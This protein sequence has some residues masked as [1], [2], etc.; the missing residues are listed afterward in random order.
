MPSYFPENN[1]PKSG[2]SA[3]RVLH[4][5]LGVLGGDEGLNTPA[6]P[7]GAPTGADYVGMTYTGDDLT[8]VVYKS[9]G[10]SGTVLRTVTLAYTD[11][12]LQ[13]MTVS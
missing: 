3:D 5:I 6:S 7:L 10:A 9:G 1:R 11:H 13:S 4:K 12:V 8:A 2:D